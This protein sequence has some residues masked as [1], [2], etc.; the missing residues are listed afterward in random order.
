MAGSCVKT[1]KESAL[2]M[3]DNSLKKLLE[4]YD[5]IKKAVASYK[6]MKLAMLCSR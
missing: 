3:D 5:K 6:H 4:W 1:M 2:E